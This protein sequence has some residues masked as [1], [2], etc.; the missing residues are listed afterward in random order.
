MYNINMLKIH[1]L[2]NN[3]T[4]ILD[5]T[6]DSPTTSVYVGVSVG[7][8]NENANQHGLAHFFEHMCFKGT[9]KYPNHL[10]LSIK[11]ESLGLLSNATT[12]NEMTTYY[13]YG[14][15]KH[16]EEMI[17]IASEMFINSLFEAEE[18]EKEKGVIVEEIKR[19]EDNHV[20]KSKYIAES[21]LFKGTQAEHDVLGSIESVKSFERS[22]FLEFYHKHYVADNTIIVISG[23]FD[24]GAVFKKVNE[25]FKD[26]RRG[27]VTKHPVLKINKTLGN[28]FTSITKKGAAQANVAISFYS[29]GEDSKKTEIAELLSVVSGVTRTSRLYNAI[30]ED[31]SACYSIYT[32]ANVL[33][34]YGVF[35]IQTGINSNNF[36]RV[37][38][39]IAVECGRLKTEQIT[40][41]ELEI[42]KQYLI[43]GIL[44]GID[45][46]NRRAGYYISEY[47]KK[48]KSR[49]LRRR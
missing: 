17:H 1:K 43:G 22:D 41:G 16:T 27:E 18:L 11:T 33:S 32:R 7:S 38:K 34:N 28:Q 37:I 20:W 35:L 15:A 47:V 9:K 5:H 44:R 49:P 46:A 30:R 10:D 12:F 26:A 31:M 48:V 45:A 8:N 2:K 42:A 21:E 39:Q 25:E 29:V 40:A 14:D 36:E 6:P 23:K 24:E 19:S 4:L 13:L 3:I